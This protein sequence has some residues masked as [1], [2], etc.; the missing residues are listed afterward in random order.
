MYG[1]FYYN[2][3]LTSLSFTIYYFY[4]S[5]LN[6]SKFTLYIKDALIVVL[7][8]IIFSLPQILIFLNS[9]PDYLTRIGL[10]NLNFDKK[11]IILDHII[12]KIFSLKFLLVFFI[13]TLFYFYLIKKSS[14]KKEGINLL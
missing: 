7:T 8:F 6:T 11:I 1:S 3:A 2:L 4:I 14:Y 5:N 10:I 9:E 12:S 13:L